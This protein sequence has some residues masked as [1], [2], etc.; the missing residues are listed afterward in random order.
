MY[1]SQNPDHERRLEANTPLLP[2]SSS[3]PLLRSGSFLPPGELGKLR[4]RL[5]SFGS[6]I[7]ETSSEPREIPA[8]GSDLPLLGLAIKPSVS[9]WDQLEELG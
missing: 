7:I 2:F 8:A 4:Q 6:K 9:L 3:L 1:V 5:T